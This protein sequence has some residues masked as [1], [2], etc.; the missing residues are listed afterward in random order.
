MPPTTPNALSRRSLFSKGALALG[1]AI[2][3]ARQTDSS[4]QTP[5]AQPS[6]K[7]PLRIIVVETLAGAQQIIERLKKGE[8]FATLAVEKSVDPTANQGGY[9]GTLDPALLRPELR[10]ALKGIR[11]GEIS[12]LVRIPEG[13]AILKVDQVINA[14]GITGDDPNTLTALTG[15]GAVLYGPDVDG[16]F[17]DAFTVF[18]ATPGKPQGWDRD[19]NP[20][21]AAHLH[22]RCVVSAIK[23]LQ[24]ML[25]PANPDKLPVVK[26]MTAH[27]LLA[28]L[29][30]FQ[31]DMA[32]AIA[33]W[34]VCSELTQNSDPK[35]ATQL[36]EVLGIAYLHKSEMENGAY[37][38]PG[39]K[40]LFPMSSAMR[41]AKTADSEKAAERF[42]RYLSQKP[43][44]LEAKWLLNL[45]YMTLGKYPASVPNQHL[46]S[47][48]GFESE[49]TVGRFLDVA[50]EAG[51][52][53]VLDAGGIIVDDFENR[54]LF[55]IVMSEWGFR[56][57]QEPM[58]YFHNNGDGTFT[59]QTERS[60]LKGMLGG[61]NI[62]QSDYNN[63]G[64]LDVLLLRGAWLYPQP[65]SLLKGHGDGTFTD[66]TKE[67]GLTELM[68]TQAAVWADINN[69]GLLDLFIGNERG[70]SHLFLNKGDGTF[71]DISASSG[72]DQ[73]AFTKGV[74]A[75]DYDNDGYIDF[76]V[77]N[78]GSSNFLYHNERNNTFKE[79]GRE[80]G[81]Q[82]PLG[83]S[84]ATWFF[85]YDNDGWPDLF[86]TSYYSGSVDENIRTYLGLPH[87]AVTLKLY[88]N[89]R[90]GTFNDVTAAVGL[91]KVFMPMGANFG[92]VDNDGFLDIY[93]G[94][95][96]PSYGSLV[97]NVLLRNDEGKRFVDITASSGTGELH[98]GHGIAF[99]DMSNNGQQ[100]I[101]TV[102]GG[103]SPGDVHAFR[104]FQNPGNENSWITVKLVGVKS[105][106]AAMGARIKVT[107]ENKG[108]GRRT[109]YRTVGSGGSFGSS[110]LEQ[111][112]GLGASARV[113]EI[114]IWWPAS[115][116]RQAFSHL[117]TNQFI[118]IREF[119]TQ[120]TPLVRPKVPQRTHLTG[121]E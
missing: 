69:D 60:G 27:Y 34:T 59:D 120:Y 54:G 61:L 26:L 78:V 10:D 84:F 72:V 30:A 16:F 8:D 21:T 4:A 33:E 41:Y 46:I 18:L 20:V 65:L 116:T 29:Y 38:T 104:Y 52:N 81:V 115:N 68:A 53:V 25:D 42:S 3:L 113:E 91:D 17:E 1:S 7:V 98:K 73:I 101:L 32:T 110:P 111:H 70:P 117:Q 40:C 43:D 108:R 95:G 56:Y 112:I 90:N 48:A 109:I 51:L 99:A 11:P 97:P 44:D 66:V 36:E 58:L 80:A 96:N 93:L 6:G 31:G 2:A 9:L 19:L 102:I 106:R 118:E 83:H 71:E 24:K 74:V 94:T 5:Q 76:Y 37:L 39:E 45:T 88:K 64:C 77:T 89:M 87:N 107:V 50:P 62:I 14:M 47:L 35:M 121:R 28:Q 85:D 15:P 55:D 13:Y 67:A 22:Q 63:D 100:D 103:V 23:Q 92:D 75:D 105:N 57:P 49:Q 114:E 12:P 119:A 86:V 82:D 79:V